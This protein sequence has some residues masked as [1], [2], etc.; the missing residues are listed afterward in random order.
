MNHESCTRGG[1]IAAAAERRALDAEERDHL[2]TC[3]ACA[4]NLA[5]AASR[6]L[7][8]DLAAAAQLPTAR[9]TLLRAR[10][11][12]RRC[13]A[14]RRLRPLVIWQSIVL[15]VSLSVSAWLAPSLLRALVATPPAQS[16]ASPAQLVFV[17]GVALLALLA[18]LS[19]VAIGRRRTV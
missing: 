5:I 19:V 18:A 8:R 13:E 11:A 17:A 12:A 16:S 9:Q 3:D 6:R 4:T 2:R 14:E 1:G 7:A 15:A 10:L